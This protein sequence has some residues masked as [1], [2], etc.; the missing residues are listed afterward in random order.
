MKEE[1]TTAPRYRIFN[2]IFLVGIF[3]SFS[4]AF[5]NYLLGSNNRHI[6][7]IPLRHYNDRVICCL[8]DYQEL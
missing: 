4:C 5:L 8:Q 6:G 3:M 7:L 2:A 1:M